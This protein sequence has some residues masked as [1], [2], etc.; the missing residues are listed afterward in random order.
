M[1][2]D[3]NH[4]DCSLPDDCCFLP[5]DIIGLVAVLVAK[6]ITSS[7][8]RERQIETTAAIVRSD[9]ERKS[10]CH[11]KS[12]EESKLSSNSSAPIY[13]YRESTTIYDAT[14]NSFI[15]FIVGIGHGNRC[16]SSPVT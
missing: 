14:E 7:S 16:L 1:A 15:L 8:S 10:A 6:T 4:L 5:S 3:C 2:A 12:R 13:T 11:Q 9:W